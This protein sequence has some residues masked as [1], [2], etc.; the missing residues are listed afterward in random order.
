MSDNNWLNLWINE[1]ILDGV[2]EEEQ[3][4]KINNNNLVLFT[5]LSDDNGFKDILIYQFHKY[6]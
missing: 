4:I 5:D 1:D 2:P 6:S 3:V